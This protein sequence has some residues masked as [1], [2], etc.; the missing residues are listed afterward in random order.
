MSKKTD[1]YYLSLD[2]RT[3]EFRDWNADQKGGMTLRSNSQDKRPKGAGDIIE[4]ITKK[5]GI[6][7]VVEIFMDGKD[8]GCD[9]RKKWLNKKLPIRYKA[10]CLTEKE[11]EDYKE[12]KEIRT[13]QINDAQRKFICRLYSNVFNRQYW[14]PCINCSPKPLIG[15]IEKLDIV[16]ESYES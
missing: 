10:R 12:F 9:E 16:F 14:E 15:M 5:T 2:R 8:C 1:E 7:K 13:L 4:I 3:K 11:Y 6:Q